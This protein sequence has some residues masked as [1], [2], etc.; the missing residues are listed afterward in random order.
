[1]DNIMA[2]H[3]KEYT[4]A[5]ETNAVLQLPRETGTVKLSC[6]L[7]IGAIIELG[8][9]YKKLYEGEWVYG[10]LEKFV[11]ENFMSFMEFW[12]W[13]LDVDTDLGVELWWDKVGKL[14]K[15]IG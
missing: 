8:Q 5:N 3:L 9:L 1:M 7:S 2:Q 10:D 12:D 11:E 6:D 15:Q 13:N 14:R 4:D